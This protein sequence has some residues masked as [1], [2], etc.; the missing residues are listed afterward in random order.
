MN[1]QFLEENRRKKFVIL[2]YRD[3]QTLVDLAGE[4]TEYRKA[5]HVLRDTKDKILEYD[6][7]AVTENP[8]L[9]V[10]QARGIS[11]RELANRLH[12]DPSYVSRLEKRGA[13]PSK[14]TLQR[15]AKALDCEV[16]E[17]I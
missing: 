16:D 5:I 7:E 4:A 6:S 15:I 8:I 17:L 12:V 13:N 3:Y 11:Q 9:Q 14:K 10:R 1:V 2:S